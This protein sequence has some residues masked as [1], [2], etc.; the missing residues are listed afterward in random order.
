MS[1]IE[2]AKR[3]FQAAGYDL[4]DTEDGPNKWMIDNVLQLLE[5]FSEQGHSG[6]SAPFALGYFEKLAKFEPLV[7]LTG[8]DFEWVEVSD[9]IY[10]NNRCSH[11]FKENGV[12]YDIDGKVFRDPD[13][14]CWTSSESRV[15][16]EF[17]YTPKTE[18]VDRD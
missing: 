1:Y 11:V 2:H 18:Y 15:D 6:S 16:V 3:E 10:Q 12:A 13:G 9:G 7:P 17:P 14:S 8:E 5:V 4:S